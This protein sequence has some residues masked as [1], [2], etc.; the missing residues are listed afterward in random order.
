MSRLST[1]L[2]ISLSLAMPLMAS[3][4][5][6]IHGSN[7]VQ[8]LAAKNGNEHEVIAQA[9]GYSLDDSFRAASYAKGAEGLSDASIQMTTNNHTDSNQGNATTE[10]G[11]ASQNGF[12]VSNIKSELSLDD[13][14]GAFNSNP[15]YHK[16]FPGAANAEKWNKYRTY[17]LSTNIVTGE[18]TNSATRGISSRRGRKDVG[19]TT[20]RSQNNSTNGRSVSNGLVMAHGTVNNSKISSAS[21]AK[22]SEDISVKSDLAASNIRGIAG[23]SSKFETIANGP[24]S[25]ASNNSFAENI[26]FGNSQSSG[27]V[28]ADESGATAS[29]FQTAFYNPSRTQAAN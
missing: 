4:S 17:T 18:D 14:K 22:G 29:G 10:A 13:K 28:T 16:D 6:F 3:D 2:L 15:K 23:S 5:P 25:E 1:L 8:S 7:N 26:G 20:N 24:D 27:S 19:V 9:K 12:A 21:K 11:S